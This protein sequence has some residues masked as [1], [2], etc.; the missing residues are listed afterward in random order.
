MHSIVGE[1]I[2]RGASDIHFEPAERDMQVRFRVDGVL[3]TPRPCRGGWSPGVISRIKIMA[4]LD[5][6]E[7][8]LPQD[9]RVGL[10]VDGRPSTSAS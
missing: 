3:A 6:S 1:A 2:E 5:I 8:R 7:K 4:E 10:T 9:G